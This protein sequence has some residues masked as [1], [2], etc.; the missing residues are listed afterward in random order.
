MNKYQITYWTL[1]D[2]K[3]TV[4]IEAATPAEAERLLFAPENEQ[5]YLC[6]QIDTITFVRAVQ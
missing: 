3:A 5:K 4:T 2:S 1:S 6:G